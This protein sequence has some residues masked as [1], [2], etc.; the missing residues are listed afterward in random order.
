M[1]ESKCF[2]TDLDYALQLIEELIASS[3]QKEFVEIR[4]ASL[5]CLVCVLKLSG[6]E[7]T[8]KQISMKT[9]NELYQL[10]M[11]SEELANLLDM[12]MKYHIG[13]D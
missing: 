8:L 9:Q 4:R 2:R 12:I 11:E 3:Y 10:R 13:K 6:S 1:T 7:N 5:I